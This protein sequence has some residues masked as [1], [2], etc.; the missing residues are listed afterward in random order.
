VRCAS[1]ASALSEVICL[2]EG[3]MAATTE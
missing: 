1:L 3:K 2:L